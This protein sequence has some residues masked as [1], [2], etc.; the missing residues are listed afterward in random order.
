MISV[1]ELYRTNIKLRNWFAFRV[2]CDSILF[3]IQIL[4]QFGIGVFGCMSSYLIYANKLEAAYL[5]N[6]CVTLSAISIGVL[7]KIRKYN[8]ESMAAEGKQR[9]EVLESLCEIECINNPEQAYILQKFLETQIEVI[10]IQTKL[11]QKRSTATNVRNQ[12][13]DL[14]NPNISVD[15]TDRTPTTRGDDNDG[16]QNL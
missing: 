12:N 10:N 1:N 5:V 15:Q 16:K 14:N 11:I 2:I 6:L 9:I 8:K 3:Y 13:S 4:L 7:S